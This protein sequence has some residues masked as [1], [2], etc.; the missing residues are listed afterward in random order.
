MAAD[1]GEILREK[2]RALGL[3]Q[4]R[5]AELVGVDFSYISKLEN[6]R[7]A[8]PAAETIAR[9]AEM[10]SCPPEELL[11]AARKFPDGL[12]TTLAQPA[13]L[14]F[15]QEAS[16]LDLSPGEWERLTGTLHRLRS[17][18]DKRGRR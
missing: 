18:P 6:N 13:A 2:R 16:Q 14:R 17:D 8:A 4:R 5:L 11:A 7:L 3:S 1:F 10:L 15:L 12:N 9:I